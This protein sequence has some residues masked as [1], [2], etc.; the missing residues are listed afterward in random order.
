M[1]QL[2][3]A[4]LV[5]VS[6]GFFQ[7]QRDLGFTGAPD[8]GA[9]LVVN[10][11]PLKASLQGN[12]VDENGLPSAGVLITVGSRTV[13]TNA[14]GY[15]RINDASLDKSSSLVVAEKSGYFRSYRVF[16]A[17]SGTNQVAI[18]MIK[19]EIAGTVSGSSGGTVTLANGT[20]ITLPANGVVDASFGVVHTGEVRV[21]ASYIDPTTA[22]IAQ[23]VPGSF[24]ADDKTGGRVI[25]TSYGMLA[26]ELET[27]GGA[28]LQVKQGSA[29]TLSMPI[30]VSMQGSA[31][32][33][34]PLWYVNETTGIW[35][36]EGLA[37][38][39]G[40]QYVGEV[41]HFSFWNC[42]IPGKTVPISLTLKTA[43]G[44]PL[45]HAS[46]QF[47][48]EGIIGGAAYGYT[49][50]LGE[51][52]GFV[53]AGRTLNLRIFDACNGLVYTQTIPAV[54]LPTELGTITVASTTPAL[55]TFQGKIVDCNN[56]PVKNGYAL[57]IINTSR[58]YANTD[59]NG[60]FSVT[61]V[62]CLGA[63]DT[64]QIIAV[65][66][67][68]QQQGASTSVATVAPTTN[69]GTLTACGTS[70][71]QYI[72]YTIDG[73]ETRITSI[74]QDSMY[75]YNTAQNELRIF[76]SQRANPFTYI[77]ILAKNVTA[78]ATYPVAELSVT[79]HNTVIIKSP[80][81]LVLTSYAASAGQFYEGTLSGQFITDSSTIV[82][83]FN[84]SFKLRRN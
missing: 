25:L 58:R 34:I 76:G 53:P 5:L 47:S 82:R 45:V 16:P 43:A 73:V 22:D 57:I 30:P 32:P 36:E 44:L 60:E 40:N 4:L 65:N 18:K 12:V 66:N 9:P 70:S 41:K 17:T 14:L 83:N 23:R 19:K 48:P 79:R 11:D 13:T 69:A 26:V 15:F 1:K 77:S 54:N 50:S 3:A 6:F 20:K 33:T 38:K 21:F 67:A 56:M 78:A 8:P 74:A 81:N 28:K 35:K 39:Q 27:P 75:A 55:V 64:A 59:A 10:A 7:C 80:F 84:G 24:M 2:Y 31:T 42:D 63:R 52:R 72:N 46:V 61:F 62:S 51:I 37:T 49:D 29:A 71:G 68:S